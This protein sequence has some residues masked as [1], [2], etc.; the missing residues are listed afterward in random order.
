MKEIIYKKG[1]ILALLTITLFLAVYFFG[2]NDNYFLTTVKV[3]AFILPTLYLGFIVFHIVKMGK[4]GIY[5]K[6]VFQFSIGT[7]VISGT[8]SLVFIFMFLNFIDEEAKN[9]LLQQHLDIKY[10]NAMVV[11]DAK[12]REM[13]LKTVKNNAVNF[14]SLKWFFYFLSG[15]YFCYLIISLFLAKMLKNKNPD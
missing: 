8:L 14:F 13:L 10:K 1:I 4:N 7:L 11:E 12:Q 3:N 5:F 6:D 9:V 2:F 15:L